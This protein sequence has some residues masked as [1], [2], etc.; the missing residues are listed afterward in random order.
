[1][2]VDPYAYV[3]AIPGELVGEI[4]VAGHTEDPAL[5]AKFLIDSHDAPVSEGVWHLLAVALQ[6]WGTK[7]VL[8]ER[9]GNI[10]SFDD[11][12]TEFDRASRILAASHEAVHHAA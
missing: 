7:P 3:R 12:L 2:G 6:A 9:D 5:G 11:L 4:H 10:P 1:V 8:V